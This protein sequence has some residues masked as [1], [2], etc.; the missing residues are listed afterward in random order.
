MIRRMDRAIQIVG[1][2][3]RF[4]DGVRITALQYLVLDH[5][6]QAADLGEPDQPLCHLVSG[7]TI[8]S[9]LNRDW[10]VEVKGDLADHDHYTITLRGARILD[11]FSRRYRRRDHICPSC[12]VK[13]RHHNGKRYIAYC[14]ECERDYQRQWARARRDREDAS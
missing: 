2:Q 14:Q 5:L 13:L 1:W 11:R 10:I 7:G 4:K 3:N 6:Q 9:L 12:G 8:T